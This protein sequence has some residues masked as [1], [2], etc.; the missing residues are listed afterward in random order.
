MAEATTTAAGTFV[1]NEV[2]TTDPH[3]CKAFYTALFDWKIREMD[4]GPSGVYT[5][6]Q[7]EGRDIGGLYKMNAHQQQMGV[8]P[9]W[10][11]YIGVE[12]VDASASKAEKIGGRILVPPT[13]IPNTGRFAVLSDPTGA[14]FAI[15]KSAKSE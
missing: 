12:D 4:M 14:A 10:L 2:G 11:T 5:I 3:A 13:D 6:F 7:M 8:P 1:W 15:Y 9:H